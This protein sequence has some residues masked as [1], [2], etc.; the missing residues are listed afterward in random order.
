MG[1]EFLLSK[2][3]RIGLSQVHQR[4]CPV[5]SGQR[6]LFSMLWMWQAVQLVPLLIL[7]R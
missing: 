1:I 7:R 4:H 3:S 2:G 6:C 5:G